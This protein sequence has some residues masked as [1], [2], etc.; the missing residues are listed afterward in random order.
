MPV[1]I[2][3]KITEKHIFHFQLYHNYTHLSGIIGTIAALGLITLGMIDVINQQVPASLIW[4]VCGGMLLIFPLQSMKAKAKKQVRSSEMFQ[5][6]LEYEFSEK[7]VTTRQGELEVTN[8]WD[9]I[10]KVVQTK[11]CVIMYMSRVRAMIFPK[12][13]IQEQYDDMMAVIRANLSPEKVKIK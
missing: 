11:K 5:H 4:F 3:V 9:K 1:K 10:E 6:P 2:N 7:G 13:C 8:E 12:E